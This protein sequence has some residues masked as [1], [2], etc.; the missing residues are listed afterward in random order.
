MAKKAKTRIKSVINILMKILLPLAATAF[1]LFGC[2]KDNLTGAS[3]NMQQVYADN[4]NKVTIA[5]GIF[6]TISSLEGDCMPG[7]DGTCTNCPAKRTVQIYQY[8]LL[9][10]ATRSGTSNDFFYSFN[11]SLVA[12]AG[13]DDNG[14]FQINIP[15]GHYSVA[16]VENGKLYA[17]QLDGQ[18]GLNPITLVTGAEKVNITMTYKASF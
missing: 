3:C 12:Q 9:N 11:T 1:A 16:V 18:G 8:A 6:G 2:H 7:S 14:F 4:A 10:N 15:P 13:T 17:N 5:T